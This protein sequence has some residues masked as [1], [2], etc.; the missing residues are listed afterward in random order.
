[1]R[2]L[3]TP[4]KFAPRKT[5]C[6]HCDAVVEIEEMDLRL[7]S[8]DRPGDPASAYANCGHC[9]GIIWVSGVPKYV[10]LRLPAEFVGHR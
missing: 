2:V 9:N 10:M 1:M 7:M 8:G 3:S 6:E 5:K 4:E